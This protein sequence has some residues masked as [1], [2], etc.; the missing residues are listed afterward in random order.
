MY[1]ELSAM[2]R[3]YIKEHAMTDAQVVGVLECIKQDVHM[4]MKL[5]AE[6]A[7]EEDE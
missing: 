1:K 7:E 4:S 2:I 5:A 6:D 3:R